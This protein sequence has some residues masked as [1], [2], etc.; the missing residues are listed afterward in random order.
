MDSPAPT[1]AGGRSG[2]TARQR[3][4]RRPLTA[5]AGEVRFSANEMHD[6]ADQDRVMAAT[7]Q[8]AELRLRLRQH[9]P[10]VRK[11]YGVASL[12]LFGSYVRDEA[13]PQSDLDVLVRFDRTPGL[14]R[15]VEMENELSDLLGIRVDLVMADALKP[16]VA[17]QVQAE[18]VAV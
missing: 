8:L 5:P 17:Q 4:A 7:R 10:A 14:I 15:F 13:G 11:R 12:A 1:R 18:L 6:D 9:L 2:A 16:D 3:I